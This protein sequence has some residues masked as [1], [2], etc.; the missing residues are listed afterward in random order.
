MKKTLIAVAALAATG[1]F[2]QVSLGGIAKVGVSTFEATGA[3]AGAAADV[4]QR[5]RIHDNSSRIFLSVNEDL[6]GGNHAAFYCETGINIDTGN[7]NGQAATEN[8]NSSEWCSREGRLVLGNKLAELRLG[9]QNVWWTQGQFSDT[10]STWL[11]T[12]LDSNFFTGGV[13]QYG[14]RIENM[15]MLNMNGGAGGFAGSQVYYAITN[16]NESTAAGSSPKGN[17]SGFKLNYKAGNAIAAIDQQSSRDIGTLNRDAWRLSLGYLYSPDS[18]V[19]LQYWNKERTDST[20]AAYSSSAGAGKDTGYVLNVKHAMGNVK[21]FAQY[22]IANNITNTTTGEKA[23]SG[24]KGWQLG[25]NYMLS[26][27]TNV[28]ATY[29]NIA[30][31]ANATYN[32]SGG[33]Y[34]SANAGAGS[35]VRSTAVGIQHSF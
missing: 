7:K 35:A 13:G 1:A 16:A 31:D 32:L 25:V 28:Y 10:G 21:L 19:S 29:L 12:S 4:Q 23:D 2:A 22:A 26:K 14:V 24:A 20:G 6:G 18:V 8:V 30:N 15:A 33:N 11:A 17:A 9:R 3:T 27:R 5:T 34:S